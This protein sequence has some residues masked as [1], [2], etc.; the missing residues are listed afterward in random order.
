MSIGKRDYIQDKFCIG[1][2]TVMFSSEYHVFVC[3]LL[4][5]LLNIFS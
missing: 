4:S 3:V 2:S 5:N 1:K